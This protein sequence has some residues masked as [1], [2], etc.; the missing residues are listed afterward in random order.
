[1]ELTRHYVTEKTKYAIQE[2]VSQ[3]KK[4]SSNLSEIVFSSS[5]SLLATFISEKFFLNTNSPLKLATWLY[6]LLLIVRFILAF[7]ISLLIFR[8]ICKIIAKVYSNRVV[9]SPDISDPEI[10]EII[11]DFDHVALDNLLIAKELTDS[12]PSLIQDGNKE[13]ATFY[14]H[15]AIYYLGISVAKTT[16]ILDGYHREKCLN[17]NGNTLGIDLFRVYNAYSMMNIIINKLENLFDDITHPNDKMKS[18][19]KDQKGRIISRIKNIKEI[20]D[21]ITN[22]HIK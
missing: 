8:K 13:I 7:V 3:N 9:H 17:I 15:E 21:E 10:K 14:Y 22:N 20:S 2:A 5:F 16:T 6:V 1:L 11:D 12:I 18:S 4:N 19:L